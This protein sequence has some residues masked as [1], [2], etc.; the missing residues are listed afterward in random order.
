MKPRTTPLSRSIELSLAAPAVIAMRVTR[1]MIAGA[2]PSSSDREEM[3]RMVSEK[4]EAFTHAWIAMASGQQQA[5]VEW[6]MAFARAWWAP[7]LAGRPVLALDGASLRAL[8][9]RWQ[10]SQEAVLD[11]GILPLH[12][13]A[14]ANLRR[15]SR[16]RAR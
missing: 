8:S 2:N 1:M 4:K 5:H 6:W 16:A 9:R 7:W 14:T 13:A 10:R 15:L 12:A 3:S 11:S